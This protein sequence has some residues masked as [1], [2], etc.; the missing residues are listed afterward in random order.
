MG[1]H[2]PEL[3]A[4]PSKRNANDLTNIR[5]PSKLE[6]KRTGIYFGPM[7]L[8]RTARE[9]QGVSPRAAVVN[10]FSDATGV[11]ASR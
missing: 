7:I 10:T 1:A 2:V 9:S 6:T 3:T 8:R 5:K 11:A 4:R